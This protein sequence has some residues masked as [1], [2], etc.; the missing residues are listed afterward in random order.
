MTSF[1]HNKYRPTSTVALQQRQWP[2]HTITQAPR[3]ASVD[4]R[5]GNQAL[6]NPM[7]VEQ[8]QQLWALLV[9][10]GFK[11]IEVGFP[12]ASQPDYDFLRWLIDE[13]QIPDEVTV[14]VL[15]QARE[16][17]ISRTFQALQGVKR[18][19]VHVYNSTSTVQR[20]RVFG[21]DRH[22][23]T[24]IA[25]EGARLLKV[26][27]EKYPETDWQFEYSPESFTSTEMDYAVE[28][29]EAVLDIWQPTPD[30]PCIINLPST[31][32]VTTPNVFA[33]QV[34]YF[35]THISRRDSL[36]LS[37]HTHND[38]GS[39]VA[40]AELAL[41]AGAN[42]VEGTLLGNGERTGNMDIIIMAMNLYS[43]GIDPELD[44]SNPSEI[45]D[46]VTACTNMPVH[47]RH[48]WIGEL[49]YTA[50]SG[51][52]QDAIRKCLKQ[53]HTD[54]PWQVAYL[55]INP[56]DLGRDYQAIVRVN[57]QSGKAGMAFVLERD[58]GLYL[59][60]WIQ[61]ELAK[62][63]QQA[64]EN[65]TGEIDSTAI[66]TLFIQ[67]FVADQTPVALLGYRLDRREHD[68]IEVSLNDKGRNHVLHGQGKGTISAFI[69]AWNQYS[70]QQAQVI[71]YHEHAMES[72][73]NAEAIAYVQL[74]IN[75][76]TCSGAAFDHDTVSASLK[77]TLSALNRQ[78][79][80][81]A[82]EAIRTLH[83]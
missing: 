46:V 7:T 78:Q 26:E 82:N 53:Q 37:V 31:V 20:E 55:P 15:V 34:E 57:S 64:T 71:D 11:E 77:A 43:Q 17:L 65:H 67:H 61:I 69:H 42:R 21:L 13:N 22:G 1:D 2:Q 23:V 9:K 59:P 52:H 81:V 14:Q 83:G 63:V 75:D 48:P 33:D 45:I 73:T 76:Q 5:D 49:V 66:Y 10:L 27:A 28:I 44:L 35:S 47:A 36:I 8:K 30:K 60:R 29:C 39:A 25:R 80:V 41:L 38:R 19:I 12:S 40:S 72:G 58:Y 16:T 32:E 3:W 18:A 70:G 6:I 4:L 62:H 68:I 54:E 79:V 51:S 74:S 24:D 50:F 56:K